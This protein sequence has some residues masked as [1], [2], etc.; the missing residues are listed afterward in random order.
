MQ[1]K[2]LKVY[3][4]CIKAMS[5][6]RKCDRVSESE[7]GLDACKH[8]GT[9]PWNTVTWGE[10]EKQ[11]VSA[12]IGKTEFAKSLECVRT[13]AKKILDRQK[14]QRTRM[15]PVPDASAKGKGKEGRAASSER[16]VRKSRQVY[17]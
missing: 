17:Q 15:V 9:A 16:I 14:A 13:K 3:V 6:G 8:F 11:R 10:D 7:Q 5:E 12:A 4:E 1:D 2:L